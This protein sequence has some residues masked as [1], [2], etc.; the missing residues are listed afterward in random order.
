MKLRALIINVTMFL[1]FSASNCFAD[2][3]DQVPKL[4]VKGEASIFKPANQM[5]ISLGVVTIGEDSS[6]A[7]KENNQKIEQVVAR[8]QELGLNDDHLQTGRFHIR[9]IYAKPP[10]DSD[11]TE[12]SKISHYEILNSIKVKTDRLDLA[13]KILHEA[14]QGGANQIDQINFSLFNPQSYKGELIRLAAQNAI[15]DASVLSEA[16]GVRIIRVI[17]LSLDHWQ[18]LPVPHLLSKGYASGGNGSGFNV[19]EP[20]NAEIHAVVNVTYEIAPLV[21]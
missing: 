18:N 20:G 12:H 10:K 17:H 15:S 7:L 8:L 2:P 1:L 16:L 21:K 5:E 19:I 11:Q 13:D 3:S 14:V 6:L 4:V 9:P